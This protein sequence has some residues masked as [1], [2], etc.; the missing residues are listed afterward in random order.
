[1]HIKWKIEKKRGN[2]RPLLSYQITLEELERE[3]AIP[4]VS[5]TSLIPVLP[6]R[7]DRFCRPHCNERN[8]HWRPKHF[9]KLST[10]DFR[11]GSLRDRIILPYP[12][13]TDYD[14]VETSFGI[15]RKAFEEEL[16]SAYDS[17][18]MFMRREMGMS[19]EAGRKMAS[20]F[21]AHRMLKLVNS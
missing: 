5:T 1:M 6:D 8:N 11:K 10:P 17:S 3:L 14:D 9:H 20:G 7:Y 2:F 13:F 16:Q 4:A 19:E 12:S 21:V 18:P 15:L